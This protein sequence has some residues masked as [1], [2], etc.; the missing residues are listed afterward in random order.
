MKIALVGT[1]PIISLIAEKLSEKNDITIFDNSKKIGGAWSWENF[2]GINIST[3]E[4]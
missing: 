3:F 4:I 2:N 1:S